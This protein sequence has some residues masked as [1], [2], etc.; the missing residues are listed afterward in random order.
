MWQI[1]SS[2]MAIALDMFIL[3]LPMPLLGRL[4]LSKGKKIGI[5]GMFS[6]ASL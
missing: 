2:S 5:A 1:V 4:Q 6:T 3:G